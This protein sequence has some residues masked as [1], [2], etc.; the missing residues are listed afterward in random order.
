MTEARKSN[1]MAQDS[2][3]TICRSYLF[4]PGS[5]PDRFAK[6]L[7]SGA[8]AII[9]DLED[10]VPPSGKDGARAALLSFLGDLP[11]QDTQ[12]F[13]RIN[14]LRSRTGLRDILELS[15]GPTGRISGLLL[16]KVEAAD[17]IRIAAAILN[18]SGCSGTLGALIETAAGL[19]TV[20]DIAAAS[21]RLAFL[22]FGG[23]DLSAELRV[24]LSWEPLAYA[25][26]RLVHAAARFG[27]DAVDMPWISLADEIGFRTELERSATAGFTARAA[28][29]PKQI[30]AIHA[31]LAPT[32]HALAHAERVLDAFAQ[33]GGGVC[34]LDGQ[35]VER[36]VVLSCRRIV[37]IARRGGAGKPPQPV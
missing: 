28:I 8:D 17:E 25:R 36:P 27:L 6:G 7:L 3:G 11:A 34:Q 32:P 20:M 31:S 10:A 21:P 16:P 22:M 1:S 30:D 14:S 26:A 18:E 29:H 24:P 9:V 15:S 5:R 35:L 2:R 37:A 4:V 19:E 23:A 13:V 12:I 33:A